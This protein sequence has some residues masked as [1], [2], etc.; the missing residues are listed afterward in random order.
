MTMRTRTSLGLTMVACTLL[1]GLATQAALAQPMQVDIGA[2][3]KH[4][5]LVVE[6]IMLIGTDY[7]DVASEFTLRVVVRNVGSGDAPPC[8]VT[9]GYS[10]N[11]GGS[12]PIVLET[13]QIPNVIKPGGST[14][15]TFTLI[16]PYSPGTPWRGMLL[17][18][19][20]PPVAGHPEG[21]I[22][23]RPVTLV[24]AGGTPPSFA[25]TNNVFGIIFHTGGPPQLPIHWANP[26]AH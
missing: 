8:T 12:S 2:F 20:D 25:E 14:L 24:A 6:K 10:S 18:V 9:L 21:Q 11:L 23:E 13:T 7:G 3:T 15:A 1:V 26:A 17:A 19:V 4:P 5:D 16:L 22:R